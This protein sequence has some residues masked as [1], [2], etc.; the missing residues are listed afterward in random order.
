VQRSGASIVGGEEG[1]GARV[2]ELHGITVTIEGGQ[3][4]TRVAIFV[5]TIY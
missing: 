1:E 3:V 5:H 4:H 2:E